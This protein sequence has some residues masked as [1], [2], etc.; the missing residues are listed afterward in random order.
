MTAD[1]IS[2]INALPVEQ[3]QYVLNA[4][5]HKEK[6]LYLAY[7]FW[8]LLGVHHFYLG[9]PWKNIVFWLS[10]FIF[11]GFFWWLWDGFTMKGKVDDYNRELLLRL[12]AEAQQ[13]YPVTYSAGQ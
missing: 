3:K 12:I 2:M 1:M 13:L 11:V 7:I 8:F 5:P 9:H 4:Y 6:Q 10:C